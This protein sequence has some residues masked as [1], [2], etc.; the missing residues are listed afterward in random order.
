M[1]DNTRALPHGSSVDDAGH[2]NFHTAHALNLVAGDADHVYAV[3]AVVLAV[4]IERQAVVAPE[5]RRDF[6]TDV[7]GGSGCGGGSRLESRV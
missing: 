4:H 3:V 5:K 2:H 7:R 6:G 1:S